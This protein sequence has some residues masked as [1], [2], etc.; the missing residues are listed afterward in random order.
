MTTTTTTTT[1]APTTMTTMDMM[2]RMAVLFATTKHMVRKV[3][4]I[5]LCLNN[6]KD[7]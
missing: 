3:L 7:S 2:A 1:T 4:G 5:L 6:I